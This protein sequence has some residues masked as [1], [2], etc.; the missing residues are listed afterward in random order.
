MATADDSIA[1]SEETPRGSTN[2]LGPPSGMPGSASARTMPDHRLH[3]RKWAVAATTAT[4]LACGA[5]RL[6]LV[7][8]M[9]RRV[10]ID[11]PSMAPAFCG[12]HYEL[13]CGDCGFPF[14]C[15]AE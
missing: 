7:D 4:L 13:P 15:D 1:K 9:L 14:R 8:G 10:T 3:R 11:G 2:L 6:S 12:S 5:L